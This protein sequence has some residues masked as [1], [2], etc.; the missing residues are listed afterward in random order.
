MS[1][2]TEA[3]RMLDAFL[4]NALTLIREPAERLCGKPVHVTVIIGTNLVD[5]VT[6]HSTLS[7][8][9]LQQVLVAFAYRMELKHAQTS[10]KAS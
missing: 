3:D 4:A 7:D 8:A 6:G 10:E 5:E 2:P 1:E 9:E